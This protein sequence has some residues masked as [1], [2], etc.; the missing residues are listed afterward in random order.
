[1]ASPY[2]Y[3]AD[4]V[5]HL[6]ASLTEQQ[7][8]LSEPGKHVKL[9]PPVKQT[10]SRETLCDISDEPVYI[11]SNRF[12]IQLYNYQEIPVYLKGNPHITCG[13]RAEIPTLLCVK[14][15]V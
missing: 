12:G 9:V 6:Q 2:Y 8:I 3:Q 15:S 5:L 13:Y 11:G 7:R 14:R 4:I 1:M 10:I